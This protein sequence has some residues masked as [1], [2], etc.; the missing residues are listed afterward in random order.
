[1]AKKEL[2]QPEQLALFKNKVSDSF[3]NTIELYDAFPKYVH[4]KYTTFR[5]QDLP[6]EKHVIQRRFSLPVK[7]D[8]GRRFLQHF[9]LKLTP[10]V[11]IRTKGDKTE[12]VFAYPSY[13]EML[14]EDVIRKIAMD[15][16]GNGKVTEGKVGCSFTIR[17]IRR[18]LEKAGHS[19]KHG[20]VVEAINVLNKCSMEYGYIEDDGKTKVSGRSPLFPEVAFRTANEIIEDGD[21]QSYVSFHRLVNKS[22]VDMTF[23]NYDF[24]TCIGYKTG[25]SNYLHKRLSQRFVQASRETSYRLTL[26]EF[27]EGASISEETPTKEKNRILKEALEELKKS[28]VVL[29][30]EV[31][32]VTDRNDKRRRID[33][34]F[35][36]KVTD[37]FISNTIKANVLSKTLLKQAVAD[38]AE[39]ERPALEGDTIK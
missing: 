22:I 9:Y 38:K 35:M 19:M 24:E 20:D 1:M 12:R 18:I 30:Y 15:A 26:N 23:R 16:G 2:V 10:A 31:T 21:C 7:D 11:I 28:G 32:P 25:I 8:E 14:V 5:E 17:Q 27:A 29:D 3:S 39:G 13:R 6:P 36:I 37:N 4:G 33:T 34:I